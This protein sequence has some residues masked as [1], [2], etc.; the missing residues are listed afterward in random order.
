MASSIPH[1]GKGLSYNLPLRQDP[2]TDAEGES[3]A[4][5]QAMTWP[6]SG[7][8][9]DHNEDNAGKIKMLKLEIFAKALV[10]SKCILAKG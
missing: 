4:G 2:R 1:P 3:W 7:W 6:L 8:Y 10:E 9:S 5:G